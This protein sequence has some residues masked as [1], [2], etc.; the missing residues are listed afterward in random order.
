MNF[1]KRKYILLTLVLIFLTRLSISCLTFDL[2]L[3]L[4]KVKPVCSEGVTRVENN[5]SIFVRIREKAVGNVK[6]I[7]PSPH[8]ELILGMVLGFNDLRS[9]P[10]FNDV[11]IRSGTIHVVVVSGYNINLVFN[12]LSKLFGSIYKLHNILILQIIAIF[13]AVITGFEPPIVRAL[14]MCSVFVWSSFYGRKLNVLYVFVVSALLMTIYDPAYIFDISFQLSSGAT[15]GLILYSNF[16]DQL[17]G[18]V[19][20]IKSI[21]SDLLS[22]L[23]AQVF[24]WPLIAHYFER[25]SI[26]SFISNPLT[27]WL[28]PIITFL[29]IFIVTLSALSIYA[30]KVTYALVHPFSYLFVLINEQLSRLSFAQS[31]ISISLGFMFIYYLLALTYPIYRFIRQ[32]S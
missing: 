12:F 26:I 9:I 1:V 13:Y 23:S 30:T 16:F 15:L 4:T 27:L 3:H 6:N 24:V 2:P 32:G 11:L 10:R 7:I 22:T 19:S 25:V 20:I 8:A 31:D 5:N 29:G 17:L 28:V 21:K 14:I 18:G